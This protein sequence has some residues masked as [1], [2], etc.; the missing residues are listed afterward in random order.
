M[1]VRSFDLRA[2]TGYPAGRIRRTVGAQGSGKIRR[3][4]LR[5]QEWQ[6]K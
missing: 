4:E 2:S 3:I 5:D 1:Y 6:Q